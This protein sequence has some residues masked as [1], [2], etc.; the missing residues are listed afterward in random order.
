MALLIK[1]EYREVLYNESSK[2]NGGDII[3][4]IDGHPVVRIED[5]ISYIEEHKFVDNNV[6]LT[7][8]RDGQ[9]LDLKATLQGRPSP[10][11]YVQK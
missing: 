10:F 6:I 1:L 11:Q 4:A 8:Y 2:T 5:L 9:S 7:V 3:T